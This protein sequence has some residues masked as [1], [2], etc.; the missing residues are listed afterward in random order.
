MKPL[1]SA[2]I[3]S[4]CKIKKNLSEFFRDKSKKDGHKSECK[5][6]SSEYCYRNR[7]KRRKNN[8]KWYKKN[9]EIALKRTKDWLSEYKKRDLEGFRKKNRERIKKFQSLPQGFYRTLVFN[10]KRR[11]IKVE[12]SKEDFIKWYK[13]AIKICA[14]CEIPENKLITLKLK[15]GRKRFSIDRI[16]SNLGY[17]KEN[18]ILACLICNQVKSNLFEFNEMKKLAKIFIKPKWQNQL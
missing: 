4:K 11:G 12:I 10:A 15:N 9:R 14:Y 6:C 3:C 2:K 17:K 16:D 1:I 5:K 18:L 8:Q 13:N 7:D